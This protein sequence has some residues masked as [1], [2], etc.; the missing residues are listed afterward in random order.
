MRSHSVVVDT[1]FLDLLS[2]IIQIH[3]PI[4]RQ[5]FVPEFPI[6]GLGIRIIRGCAWPGEIQYDVIFIAPS[7]HLF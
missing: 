5:A 2:C 7:V 1:K 4:H 3:K 6:K